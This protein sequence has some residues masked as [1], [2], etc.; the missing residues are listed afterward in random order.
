MSNH[1]RNSRARHLLGAL[2]GAALCLFAQTAVAQEEYLT[3]NEVCGPEVSAGRF[4]LAQIGPQ[5]AGLYEGTAPGIG[6]TR[7]VETFDVE[8]SYQNGRVYMGG[9]GH[10][11]ELTPVY[12]MRK[13][14][15]Y[16]PIRQAP[17]PAEALAAQISMED[18][19]LSTG[20]DRRIAPQFTWT[21]GSG[22]RSSGGVYSFLSGDAALGTMWN[23]AKGAREVYL[24]RKSKK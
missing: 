1:R 10:K 23:S 5:I 9:G 3:G 16:D 7:G 20:C 4:K 15:R 18:I 8:I 19:E 14:L 21:A 22:A 17:L 24:V 6:F 12:G 11:V 13:E 2:G